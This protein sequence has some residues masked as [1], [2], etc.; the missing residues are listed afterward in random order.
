MEQA[1]VLELPTAILSAAHG[2]AAAQAGMGSDAVDFA[3]QHAQKVPR[4]ASA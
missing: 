3:S 4:S 1:E 2:G